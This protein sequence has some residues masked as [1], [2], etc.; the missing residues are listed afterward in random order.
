MDCG[1]KGEM[2]DFDIQ[3]QVKFCSKH[4]KIYLW[5]VR[6]GT[7]NLINPTA[8]VELWREAEECLDC[9]WET[10]FGEKNE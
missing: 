7:K 9:V 10:K 2:D 6:A 8:L 5:K 1:G 4:R 3:M